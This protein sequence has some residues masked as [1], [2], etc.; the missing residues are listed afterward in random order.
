M[1]YVLRLLAILQKVAFKLFF[2]ALEMQGS[3]YKKIF[4][5]N[6]AKFQVNLTSILLVF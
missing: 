3:L 2:G 6:F 1:A 5:D 4:R